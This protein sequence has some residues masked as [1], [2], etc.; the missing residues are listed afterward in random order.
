MCQPKKGRLQSPHVVMSLVLAL[1][2]FNLSLLASMLIT[3]PCFT[4]FSSFYFWISFSLM[5][6][7][8]VLGFL[9]NGVTCM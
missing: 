4:T 7:L 8:T 6:H 5:H 2:K 3:E 1:F 9:N